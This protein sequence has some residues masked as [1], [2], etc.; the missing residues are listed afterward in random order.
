[1]KHKNTNPRVR[2][3]WWHVIWWVIWVECWTNKKEIDYK[4][5]NTI[6]TRKKNIYYLFTDQTKNYPIL[7]FDTF[8]RITTI[9]DVTHNTGHFSGKQF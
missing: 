3:S 4:K 2:K 7:K 5:R 6:F 1:M 9:T 8:Q